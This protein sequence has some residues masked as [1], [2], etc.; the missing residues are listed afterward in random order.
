MQYGFD[1]SSGPVAFEVL[2]D[3]TLA[4]NSIQHEREAAKG[5]GR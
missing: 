4:R 3:L 5:S 1:W 2:E